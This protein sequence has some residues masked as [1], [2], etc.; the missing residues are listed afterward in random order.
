MTD[1]RRAIGKAGEDLALSHYRAMGY[2]LIERNSRSRYGEIDLIVLKGS[3]LVFAEVRTRLE[4]QGNPLEAFGPGKARQVRRM[5]GAWLSARA[6]HHA[7]KSIRG[8]NTIRLDAVAV[9]LKPDLALQSLEVLE[10]AL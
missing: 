5:A 7:A 4:G 6:H 9:T 3:D 1:R 8:V 10:A 2:E